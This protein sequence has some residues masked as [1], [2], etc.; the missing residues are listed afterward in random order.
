MPP[1]TLRAD[2]S[3]AADAHPPVEI[4]RDAEPYRW[5]CPNGHTSWDRTNSHAWCI[6]CRRA[7]ENGADV[8]PE[9]WELVDAKTDRT[10]PY[11]AVRFAG[12]DV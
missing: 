9:H 7:A 10:I 1:A 8:T 5:R 4:D 6:S 12:D 2:G 3:A 11:S